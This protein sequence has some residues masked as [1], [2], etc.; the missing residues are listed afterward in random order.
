MNYREMCY[1]CNRPKSSCLC[2]DIKPIVTNTKFVILMH[3]KEFKYIKNNTGRLTYLSLENS[4]L[5]VGI[6]FSNHLKI[7]KLIND[8][9]NYCTILYPSKE[10]IYLNEEKL[11]LEGKQLIIFIID[12][13]WDSSKPILRL[14]RNLHNLPKISFTHTKTSAYNFKR[15]PFTEALSTIESTL[16]VLEILQNQGLETISKE[17]LTDFLIPFEKM[18]KFQMGFVSSKPR[19]RKYDG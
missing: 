7:N 15:Q 12:A 6:D 16:C 3:P 17:A 1:D 9:N 14:S 13:T 2:K 4:E 19:F 11:N 18:I 10:S 8:P 5:F